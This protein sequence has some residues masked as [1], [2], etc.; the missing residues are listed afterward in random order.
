M[1][2]FISYLKTERVKSEAVLSTFLLKKQREYGPADKFILRLMKDIRVYATL[3]G[4]M[5]R[6]LLT[7]LAY[8]IC[9]GLPDPS[10]YQASL[11]ME[12][13]HRYLLAHDD[14][15]DQDLYRHGAPTLQKQYADRFKKWY[16]GK[17]DSTYSL[18]IQV[19]GGDLLQALV[20]QTVL[21]SG[22][23][24][25]VK[26]RVIEGICR[27][28]TD[29][30]TGW[31]L[32]TNLKQMPLTE[33]T[34]SQVKKAMTL[35][36]G[37]YS[38]LWPLRIGQL[39]AG[40]NNYSP[41]LEKYGLY[42]GLAFQLQDDLLGMFGKTDKTGKPVGNDHRE[43]KKTLFLLEA[44]KRAQK[45]DKEILERTLGKEINHQELQQV[46]EIIRKTGA[47]EQAIKEAKSY[48]QKGLKALTTI[49]TG[50]NIQAVEK[51]AA[52]AEYLAQREL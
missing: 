43:G 8:F 1:T 15:L 12:L 20:Y 35:V 10:L 6:P 32:E 50:K 39:L 47:Y 38:V 51:L 16:P 28:N 4:K 44:Y 37:R 7:R 9:G 2:D 25:A 33:V 36:S 26:I 49:K 40:K 21:E 30:C 11:A 45:K 42:V 14:V 18:S 48:A 52:L 41:V 13:L 5:H 23:P 34:A 24:E 31:L 22:F 46:Q 19:V 17:T 3:G 27:D 29:T